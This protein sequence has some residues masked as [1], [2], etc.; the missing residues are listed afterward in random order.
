MQ[1]K[2]NKLRSK[3]KEGKVITGSVIYSWSPNVMEVCGCAGLDFMRIDNEHAWR[4]DQSAE[5]LIRAATVVDVVP[6]V[7][8]DR[9][10]PYLIRKALE[11]G[12]GAVLVPNLQTP[13]EV[14]SVVKASKFPPLG[15]R[16]YSGSCWSASW[17]SKAGQDWVRWSDTEPMIGIMVE[18]VRIMDHLD[19][20][21]SI[22]GLDYVYF[23]PA[24]YSMSLGLGK[25]DKNNPDVQDALKKTVTAA[26]KYGKHVAFGVGTNITEIKRYMDMGI[27]MLELGNDLNILKSVWEQTNHSIRDLL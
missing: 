21:L 2:P 8:I 9:D 1:R 27:T 5:H 6:L 3:L 25:P 15:I 13:E 18:N 19:E 7:R 16:G 24:D 17:G 10:N 22:D 23:G 4:Q 20:V 26:Q 14:L 12:A 11:I